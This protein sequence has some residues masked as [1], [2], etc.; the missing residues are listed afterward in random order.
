MRIRRLL[1]RRPAAFAGLM[2]LAFGLCTAGSVL[3]RTAFANKALWPSNGF[4]VILYLA[5]PQRRPVLTTAIA[6]AIYLAVTILIGHRA[7]VFAATGAATNLFECWASAQFCARLFGRE[8]DFTR[9]KTLLGFGALCVLPAVMMGGLAFD[10]VQFAVLGKVTLQQFENWV[11][12]DGFGIFMLVPPIWVLLFDRDRRL[13]RSVSREGFAALAILLLGECGL[14]LTSSLPAL[15]LLF[16]VLVFISF[17]HGPAGAARAVL[18]TNFAVFLFTVAGQGPLAALLAGG[19]DYVASLQQLFVA[20]VTLTALPVAGA[21]AEQARLRRGLARREGQARRAA[22]AKADFLATMSHELRTPLHSIIAF[23]NFLSD[24]PRID[25]EEARRVGVIREASRSLLTVVD[26]ILDYSK[27]EAGRIELAPAPFDLGAWLEST[28]PIVGDL[29]ERKG[30]YLKVEAADAALGWRR[31]DSSRL[32]QVL[33][34]LLNNAV[35]FTETGGVV[36]RIDPVGGEPGEEVLRFSV[37]DTGVGIAPRAVGTL[38]QRFQQADGSISRAFGGTGLG[39]AISKQLIELMGGRIGVHSTLGEGSTFWFEAPLPRSAPARSETSAPAPL[40]AALRILLV[41]DLAAN[42]EIG[43]LVL[44]A[45]GCEVVLASSAEEAL[46]QLSGQAFD[47]VLMDVHMPGTDGL[48]A[49][50]RIRASGRSWSRVPVVA[51]TANVLPEQ[52][53]M[54]LDAGMDEHVGKPFR[55]DD[56]IAAISR[57]TAPAAETGPDVRARA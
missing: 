47:A 19:D 13:F 27:I 40:D 51:M 50:R 34:N 24:S 44:E 20:A 14:F 57:A 11:A 2:L 37:I 5:L 42:R 33:L 23:S 41:D 49:T 30:L 28:T 22:A 26:D 53:R 6:A 52:V 7:P 10:V 48:E 35:K 55:P 3:F 43:R 56:L 46:D 16:P 15:F 39:L 18:L 9:P 38:F 54:C 21:L 29:A 25:G 31:A 4:L 17:R 45:F 32:R 1:S 36:L 12:E 8:P